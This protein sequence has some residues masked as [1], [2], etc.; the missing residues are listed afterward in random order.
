[1]SFWL[2]RESIY[3]IYNKFYTFII[4]CPDKGGR[5]QS[6]KRRDDNAAKLREQ[7]KAETI[8]T[9]VDKASYVVPEW[10]RNPL[11]K[12]EKKKGGVTVFTISEFS[13]LLFDK[14]QFVV[15]ITIFN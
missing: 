11:V 12:P 9:D 6:S 3:C 13:A 10:Y 15:F 5:A 8:Q 1:M 4:F 14:N 2:T 7:A